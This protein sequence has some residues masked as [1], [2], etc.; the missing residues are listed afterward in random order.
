MK[1]YEAM[2]KCLGIKLSAELVEEFIKDLSCHAGEA[3]LL[4]YEA[5]MLLQELKT[6][7]SP[8]EDIRLRAFLAKCEALGL[9]DG[10]EQVDKT[11]EQ[12]D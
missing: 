5:Y 8:T 1:S 4:L 3:D 11:N 9:C 12:K 10:D 6:R 7:V 2:S